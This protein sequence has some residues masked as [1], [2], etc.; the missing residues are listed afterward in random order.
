MSISRSRNGRKVRIVVTQLRI[1]ASAACAAVVCFCLWMAREEGQPG[2]WPYL[3]II[4]GIMTVG[5]ALPAKSVVAARS[6]IAGIWNG[7]FWGL[8]ATGVE[9]NTLRHAFL[10][11]YA[12]LS[13]GEIAAFY[14]FSVIITVTVC[15]SLFMYCSV[16]MRPRH[17]FAPRNGESLSFAAVLVYLNATVVSICLSGSVQQSP[18]RRILIVLGLLCTAVTTLLLLWQLRRREACIATASGDR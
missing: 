4:G 1:L 2:S 10:N 3:C 12:R 8:L 6:I 5:S 14:P 17:H 15:T 16:A 7:I 13:S 11:R 9:S 18:D